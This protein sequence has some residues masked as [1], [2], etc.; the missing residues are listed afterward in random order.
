M[1]L[2]SEKSLPSSKQTKKNKSYSR[3][4][5]CCEPCCAEALFW[6]ISSKSKPTIRQHELTDLLISGQALHGLSSSIRDVGGGEIVLPTLKFKQTH[7]LHL[8][9]FCHVCFE[10]TCI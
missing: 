1:A 2:S 10:L 6:H 4:Y 8:P 7:L 3:P 5:V 9:N